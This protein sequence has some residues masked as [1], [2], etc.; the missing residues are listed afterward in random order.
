MTQCTK[1]SSCLLHWWWWRWCWFTECCLL[2]WRIVFI[3]L[4]DIHQSCFRRRNDIVGLLFLTLRKV[5]CAKC[6]LISL[7]LILFWRTNRW[8]RNIIFILFWILSKCEV[9]KYWCTIIIQ[10]VI[11]VRRMIR[12]VRR[13]FFCTTYRL[14]EI[15]N[16]KLL[17]PSRRSRWASIVSLLELL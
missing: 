17:W 13:W 6:I 5:V 1:L 15:P 12:G 10:S 11:F 4:K 8:L 2:D 16:A 14:C 3:F 9:I 7:P